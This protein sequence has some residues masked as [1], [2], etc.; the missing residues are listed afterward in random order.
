M[1]SRFFTRLNEFR[2][3]GLGV[4]LFYGYLV[5]ILAAVLIASLAIRN[6][7]DIANKANRAA[8]QAALAAIAANR[9]LCAQKHGYQL[10]YTNAKEY[11]KKH[12]NGTKDFSKDVIV[13]A[14]LNA[15]VQLAAFKDVT[16]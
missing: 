10:T 13:A 16:C 3:S 1:A 4:L 11:L 7:N 14:I 8:T 15:K 9:G 12:P 2:T 6:N 5:G